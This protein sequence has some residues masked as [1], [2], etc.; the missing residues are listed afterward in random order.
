MT[1]AP[2]LQPPGSRY[3]KQRDKKQIATYPPVGKNVRKHAKTSKDYKLT[4]QYRDIYKDVS[5]RL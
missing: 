1:P 2:S 3:T 4:A 5:Q